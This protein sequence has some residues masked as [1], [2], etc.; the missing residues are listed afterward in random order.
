M[1]A[2]T[3]AA[4]ADFLIDLS[5]RL[6]SATSDPPIRTVMN[7]ACGGRLDS[8]APDGRPAS[9]L[10]LSGLPFETSVSGGRGRYSPA[11]RYVTESA[12]QLPLFAE[13]VTTQLTA[14]SDLLTWLPNAGRTTA[15]LVHSFVTALYPDPTQVPA[16]QRSALW[17]G[18][19]HHP[20]APQHAARLKVYGGPSVVPGA[21]QRL[22]NR[23]PDFADLT[24]VPE[25]DRFFRYAGAAIEADALGQVSHKTYLAARYRDKAVPMK[26][27]RHFGDP[28]WEILSE[29]IRA[30]VDATALH[31][32]SFFACCTG[33]SDSPSFAL[34]M[35]P[36]RADQDLTGLA[37]ELAGRHHGSTY[38]VDA[39]RQAARAHGARWRYSGI[40]LGFS[41]D[42]GI[43]KLNVYGTPTWDT[44]ADAPTTRSGTAP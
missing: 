29:L 6:M 8:H 11:V 20:E 40:G 18:V 22:R 3:A 34:S 14:I 24:T 12:T 36:R 33:S 28:A 23:W 42:Y 41:A 15:D 5:G 32:Y 17:T 9:G 21:L 7:I 4:A 30:G 13:R 10:T 31:E 39:L 44:A 38:A 1:T 26:L 43:D 2:T 37:R 25:D 27:V 19:V 35:M 16:R